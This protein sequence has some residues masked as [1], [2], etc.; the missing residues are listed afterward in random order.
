MA[1]LRNTTKFIISRT[2]KEVK[3]SQRYNCRH[4]IRPCVIFISYGKGFKI[5][6]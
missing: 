3:S 5:V 1:G 4:V 6:F 2:E